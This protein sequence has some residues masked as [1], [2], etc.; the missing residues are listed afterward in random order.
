MNRMNWLPAISIAALMSLLC[1]CGSLLAASNEGVNHAPVISSTTA[2]PPTTTT[3]GPTTLTCN[4]TD[5]DGDTLSFQWSGPGE[6]ADAAA[7]STSWSS[8]TAGTFTL[9]CMVSDPDDL[10]ATGTVDVTVV[11]AGNQAP[12][13][14]S[15]TADPTAVAPGADTT[16]TCDA[17]EPD[18][19][20][21]T[22]AW[23]GEGTF[24]AP[25]AATTLWHNSATGQFE[26]TCTVTDTQGNS[27][28]GTV[29]V[30]VTENPGE[31]QPPLF[32]EAGI[33]KDVTA[34]VATQKV[35]FSI[36][37]SDPDSDPLTITW[38]DGTG[39]AN[40]FDA[41]YELNVAKVSWRGPTAGNFTITVTADDGRTAA[42]VVNVA[43]TSPALAVTVTPLPTHFD[44][45]GESTCAGC[46]PDLATK[47]LTT[48]HSSAL[49]THIDP[50]PFGFRNEACYQCHA[51]GFPPIGTG[52]FIDEELTPQFANIQCEC[53]HGGGNPPGAGPGHKPIPWDPAIGMKDDPAE[54]WITDPAY[55]GSNGYGCGV[56]HQGERHGAFNEW[57]TSVHA[58]FPVFQEDG[59]TPQ[60]NVVGANCVKCHNG[61]FFVDIQINGNPPPAD[62]LTSV[63]PSSVHI[64]CA[65]CHDNHNN[66]FEEQLRVDSTAEVTIPFGPTTSGTQVNAGIGN[67]CIMCHNGRRNIDDFNNQISNGSAHF[68]FHH[69]SQG[70]TLFGLGGA[71]FSGMTYTRTHPHQTMNPNACVTCHMFRAGYDE[72]TH[73]PALWGHDWV[74]R[75]EACA[76]CHT[77]ITDDASFQAFRDE[78]QNNIQDLLTQI[79]D[80]WPAA[81]K[82]TSTT[83][84]TLR[85][86]E[87]AVGAGDGPPANDPA[88]GDLYRE[89]LWDYLYVIDDGSLGIHNPNYTT[90]LLQ[91]AIEELNTL[92][93]GT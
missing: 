20:A 65:V 86:V 66:Q 33:T 38:D 17:T 8:D 10:S 5:S 93:A 15:I 62:D 44:W 26:L 22:F 85:N 19:E 61:K 70:T 32:G 21:M 53:C 77:Q 58:T 16:L 67:T 82:D 87:S 73:T 4:A 41:S 3:E 90:D 89:V 69:N 78:F 36:D 11:N 42:H 68:G 64:S 51:V 79:E 47:W 13:I 59:V 76:T 54:G 29:F 25:D 7:P 72:V 6:F 80:L 60:G 46:H 1:S 27:T 31:N 74:P 9:T 35:I 75:F 18:G 37:V 92:N 43:I 30:S 34:P 81:W 40:F 2:T 57:I 55:D 56:C 24:A 83:P 50:S 12:I 52:G 84:P 63:D 49:Q 71:E 23:T 48:Q 88:R 39:S 45:V 28:L 14:N 91:N